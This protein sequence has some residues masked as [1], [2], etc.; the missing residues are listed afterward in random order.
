MKT[1]RGQLLIA[2]PTLLDPNFVRAVVLIGE[3]NADGALGVVLNRPSETTV[4]EAVPDLE[5]LTPGDDPVRVGG[6]VQPSA[7]LVLAEYEQPEP[8]T[9]LVT[10]A[11]G[12]VAVD[13]ESDRVA[14]Q[15]G[16]A[17][18]FAG[19]AGWGPGQLEAELERDDWIIADALVDDIFDSDAP[20]LWSRVL[21][22]QGGK[23]RLIAR[24][25][26]DPTL[27]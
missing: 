22:R 17:R 7:V 2:G 11:V 21:D 8:G 19:Y 20:T 1:L 9:Q 24:M 16:R 12:F 4:G 26:L 13:D 6:P 10:G 14:T 3:H 18:V 25:P 27:N 23:L 5:D 15:L